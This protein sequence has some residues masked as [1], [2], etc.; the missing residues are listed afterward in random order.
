[1]IKL[2]KTLLLVQC[3]SEWYCNLINKDMMCRQ[4]NFTFYAF[5]RLNKEN[6]CI[7]LQSILRSSVKVIFR[8]Y[9]ISFIATSMPYCP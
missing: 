2:R 1:M 7:K 4:M 6:H 5:F 8:L 3:F 9:Q